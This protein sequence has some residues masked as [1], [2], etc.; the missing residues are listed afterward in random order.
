[1]DTRADVI[2]A[3]VRIGSAGRE[4]SLR[5][6]GRCETDTRVVQDLALARALLSP[7][8]H[9]DNRAVH[10]SCRDAGY[11]AGHY[12]KRYLGCDLDTYE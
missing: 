8:G 2:L 3:F 11:R 7:G 4:A 1:M 5:T 12:A 9:L 6:C 10:R